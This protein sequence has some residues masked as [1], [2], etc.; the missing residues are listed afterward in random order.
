MNTAAIL[1]RIFLLLT[2]AGTGAATIY[3]IVIR[4]EFML[5]FPKFTPILFWIYVSSAMII[6]AGAFGTWKWKKWGIQLFTL[7]FLV[8]MPLELYAGLPV[9]KVMRIPIVYAVLWLLLWKNRKR[10]T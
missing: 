10:L 6:F 1:L 4:Q 9:A 7:A 5:Q 2:M 8:D 3:F